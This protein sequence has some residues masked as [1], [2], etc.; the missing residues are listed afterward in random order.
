[1]RESLRR[2]LPHLVVSML[3]LLPLLTGL[4]V[5]R[6]WPD[7][8]VETYNVI[9][10]LIATLFIAIAVE[11]ARST[12]LWED[13]LDRLLVQILIGMSWTGLFTCVR[14]LLD[15]GT[16]LTAGLAAAGLMSASV[17]VWLALFARMSGST[18]GPPASVVLVL[19]TP[20]VVLLLLL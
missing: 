16:S 12:V 8:D 5:A 10:Q 15:G 13:R 9:A 20:P 11:F 2:A 18:S 1:M 3:V 6:R 14:A 17:L 4:G 7:A 19:L